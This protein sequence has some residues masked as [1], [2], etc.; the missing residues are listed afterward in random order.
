MCWTRKRVYSDANGHKPKY[1]TNWSACV[2]SVSRTHS[3][4]TLNVCTTF[5]GI[6]SNICWDIL[7][8][9]RSGGQ[10]TLP[11]LKSHAATGVWTLAHWLLFPNVELKA[12]WAAGQLPLVQT[13]T[14]CADTQ[15]GGGY[16]IAHTPSRNTYTCLC[17]D[18]CNTFWGNVIK[19]MCVYFSQSLITC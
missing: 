16:I 14:Q 4:G 7:G 1:W 3:L 19:W 12:V 13:V 15:P 18:S 5:N 17:P 11:F 10:T 6:S 9:D 2:T 8:L